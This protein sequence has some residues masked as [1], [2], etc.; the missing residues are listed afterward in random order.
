MTMKKQFAI[1]AGIVSLTAATLLAQ[2][3]PPGGAG[4]NGPALEGLISAGNGPVRGASIVV[5]AADGASV[6]SVK[7]NGKGVYHIFNL[8][9]GI[10]SVRVTEDGFKT[11]VI[12]KVLVDPAHHHLNVHL[13]SGSSSEVVTVVSADEGA[14][15][16][17]ASA[18]SQSGGKNDIED[19]V[20]LSSRNYSEVAGTAKGVT[21]AVNSASAV[22]FVSSTLF[23]VGG[24]N[25]INMTFDGASVPMAENPNPDATEAHGI[26]SWSYDAGPQRYA[27]VN[28]SSTTKSGGNQFHGSLFEY[29]RNDVFNANEYFLKA[30]G[31]SRPVLKQN[32][33]G[34]TV[35]GPILH[36]KLY[37]FTSYQGTRQSNGVD[38]SGL[39]SG[40]YTYPF[41]VDRTDRAAV[42]AAMCPENHSSD[43]VNFQTLYGGVQVDC[44]GKNISTVA[45]N[46]LQAKLPNGNYVIPGSGTD[47]YKVQSFSSPTS[48]KEDQG[49]LNFDYK[50]SA[51]NVIAERGFISHPRKVASFDAGPSS[52]PGAPTA[53]RSKNIYETI[54]LNSSITPSFANELRFSGQRLVT[55]P[56]PVANG[57]TNSGLGIADLTSSV[58]LFDVI[59]VYHTFTLGGTDTAWINVKQNGLELADTVAWGGKGHWVRA[60]FEGELHQYNSENPG[61]ARGALTI[62]T[63]S[64][65]LIGRAGCSDTTNS[66]C[67]GTAYSNIYQSTGASATGVVSHAYRYRDFSLYA[68]DSYKLTQR[69]KV[70]YGVRWEFYGLP[71]DATGNMTTFSSTYSPAYSTLS[72]DGSFAGYIVP[73]NFKGTLP[74][75]DGV[76]RL[77]RN[78]VIEKRE[79]PL[80]ISPRIGFTWQPLEKSDLMVTAGYG[81]FYDILPMNLLA[82]QT[83]IASP[84]GVLVGASGTA[85]AAATL[86]DP[87]PNRSLG[88]NGWGAARAYDLSANSGSGLSMTGFDPDLTNPQT[89]K[90]NVE[91]SKLLPGK[92]SFSAGYAGAHSIHLYG[93]EHY[94]NQAKLA[95]ASS[96]V[97]G[98]TTNSV[99]NVNSRVPYLGFGATGLNMGSSEGSAKH[100]VLQMEAGR[101]FGFG[102]NLNASYTRTKTLSNLVAGPSGVQYFSAGNTLKPAEM[103]GDIARPNR[104]SLR[105]GF[106][107]PWRFE[108]GLAR[109]LLQD[110]SLFGDTILQSGQ[111]ITPLD[112]RGATLYGMSANSLAQFGSGYNRHN[113]TSTG[114]DTKRALNGWFKSD[115][116]TTPTTVAGTNGTDWGNGGF[117]VAYGPHQN[118]TNL[119]INKNNTLFNQRFPVH[120]ETRVE[121]YNAFNHENFN[122]P[123]ANVNQGTAFGKVTSSAVNPRLIQIG[124]KFSY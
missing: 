82:T 41:P 37:F 34:F 24:S 110:W 118:N 103:Y 94:I 106:R 43:A 70:D 102:L 72:S 100:N 27:G 20:P 12:E 49:V 112:S 17:A 14:G 93:S 89:Q 62:E 63:V 53:T 114:S 96:P 69:L 23:F 45:M 111:S 97:N 36:R 60:G 65:L 33:F 46:L 11:E 81:V 57:I 115:A 55:Q 21:G 68:M 51:K 1:L 30:D 8:H 58:D 67:N 50:I 40:V 79:S 117:A 26:S 64:D 92:I 38:Q 47:D 80:H 98:I 88:N 121:L 77:G 15:N 59:N 13:E 84:Y 75:V 52:L 28:M 116:Y 61:A 3:P 54:R 113:V 7:T 19:N 86:A 18:A 122:S 105:Y 25:Q 124:M 119:S 104:F 120:M 85:N 66:E 2:G 78:S 22:G 6:K 76:T 99:E 42:G 44:E 95:S 56:S 10:Y 73:K 87:Y 35:G 71:Y 39:A 29:D 109:T 83:E 123:N 90:W 5:S 4:G 48:Y 101:N 16:T 108:H 107:T 31:K 9:A 91:I 74:S 32:Q